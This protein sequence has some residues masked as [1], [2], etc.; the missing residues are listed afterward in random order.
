MALEI[1]SLGNA[2]GAEILG[3]DLSAPLRDSTVADIRQAWLDHLVLVLRGQNITP[4]QHIDF[5]ARL[6]EVERGNALSHY[7]HPDHP[8]IFMVTN[9]MIDGKPSETRNTGRQWHSD[10]SYTLRP[11]M[12]SLLNA[13]EI[14]KVG[15]DTM[16]AN[17]YRA[18]ETLSAPLRAFIDPLS[19]VHDFMNSKDMA[20]RDPAAVDAMKQRTPPVAQPLVRVHPETGRKALYVHE[21]S[22]VAIEGLS[23]GESRVILDL[24]FHHA[25]SHENVYRHRWQLHD[26]LMWDNRCVQHIALFDY[27]H[28]S[29]RHMLRTTLV[30]TPSGRA[31]SREPAAAAARAVSAG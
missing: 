24:L 22:T 13:R 18:Y 20:K 14:P 16:F 8:E 27:E 30:G 2:L 26:L 4:R 15:G 17:M 12:G 10:L 19:A 11:P 6:G 7:N 23:E 29:P 21:A 9:H 31:L 1:N 3:L 5:S 25:T 28:S